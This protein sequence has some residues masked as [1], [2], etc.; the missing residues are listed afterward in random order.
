ME[1]GIEQIDT[2]INQLK[3]NHKDTIPG[4]DAFLLYDTFGFPLDLTELIARENSIKV[5]IDGFN[6]KMD[7][8]KER[9]RAARKQT[10]QEIVL[11]TLDAK[12]DFVG[13]DT[14]ECEATILYIKDDML[15]L[16]KTPFYVE[17]GGQIGDTGEIVLNESTT[18]R[19]ADVKKSGNAIFHIIDKGEDILD[20]SKISK[21]GD[22][23]KAKVDIPRRRNI[24]RNHTAT[25]LLHEAL[26]KVLGEHLHQSG[27]L[28]MDDKLRFDFNHFEKVTS[29]QLKKIENIVNEQIIAE[30]P[31]QTNVYTIEEAKQ[32][33]QIKMFFGDKYGDI[34]RAVSA[35]NFA[36]ELCGGTHTHNTCEIL[37][38]KI[39]SESSI[40]AGI[41]RIEAI[42]GEAAI[43]YVNELQQQ[44][45]ADASEIETLKTRI[46]QYEKE[47]EKAKIEQLSANTADFIANAKEIK[48]IKV[49]TKQLEL[50]NLDQ[51]R[52]TAEN[53]RDSFGKNGVA[54]IATI[55]DDKIQLACSV[56]DDL[57]AKYPA[58]KLVGEAAKVL[59]GGG[60]G[61][62][63]LATAGGKDLSK[64]PELLNT[65][66][67]Q[68]VER[69]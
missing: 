4:S 56:T 12:T 18:L 45:E 7:E 57:K 44:I 47:I 3:T 32:N 28:V 33:S 22:K 67:Y 63:H 8:Q 29:E 36:I 50:E 53:I 6:V 19:I 21:V 14:F 34:V 62:P 60:G 40:A 30:L 49:L 69:F 54:L 11:P 25:H 59:G 27:S 13:Y 9:S 31:V 38:F 37:L 1:R 2:I 68:I 46:K 23:V 43:S 26:R 61:K 15:V 58:G 35:G 65:T 16:D 55:I 51:L 10:S 52:T 41:R 24:M 39:I 48:E 5:D 17:M 64:L 42:T 66:F 20:I